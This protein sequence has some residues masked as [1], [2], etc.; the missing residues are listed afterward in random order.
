MLI[1]DAVVVTARD[2]V[3]T[4][5]AIRVPTRAPDPVDDDDDD[6]LHLYKRKMSCFFNRVEPT[7]VRFLAFFYFFFENEHTLFNLYFY[8]HTTH[9][10]DKQTINAALRR[11]LQY[12]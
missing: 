11:I 4:R 2:L 8:T 6:E 10:Q 1:P 7:S 9:T 12:I 3:R 5:R